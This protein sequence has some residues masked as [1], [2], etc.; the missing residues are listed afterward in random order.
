M[1]S[2]DLRERLACPEC[3]EPA[4][5]PACALPAAD[6]SACLSQYSRRRRC[7][8]GGPDKVRLVPVAEGLRCP[9]CGVVFGLDLENGFV[10]LTPPRL[11]SALTQ[12]ADQEFH[13]RLQV[14]D[15]PPFLSARIKA[16]MMRRLLGLGRDE[17]VLDLGCGAGKFAL[18]AAGHSVH[19][20]GDEH[21]SH[22]LTSGSRR[23]VN[24]AFQF[25]P[26]GVETS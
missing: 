17:R 15:A 7:P 20:P 23:L 14:K 3:L 5:C 26:I 10:D 1:I 6:H 24:R 18:Y 22:W 21:Y 13:E 9:C 4:G 19:R 16:D 2:Q 12:Y 11:A 25:P 8:C